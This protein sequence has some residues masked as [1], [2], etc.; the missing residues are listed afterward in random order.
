MGSTS[1]KI[2]T[3]PNFST[4]MCWSNAA[5]ILLS[6]VYDEPSF[7]RPLVPPIVIDLSS[8]KSKS[9]F[10]SSKPAIMST[11][12]ASWGPCVVLDADY[13]IF[14]R[15]SDES[16]SAVPVELQVSAFVDS[17]CS[18]QSAK[19]KKRKARGDM[20]FWMAATF[21]A[22]ACCSLYTFIASM[23]CKI[24]SNKRSRSFQPNPEF[25]HV[26]AA[27]FSEITDILP[28]ATLAANVEQAQVLGNAL[29]SQEDACKK[30]ENDTADLEGNDGSSIPD[31]I[32]SVVMPKV[33]VFE[34]GWS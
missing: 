16:K 17:T 28:E 3:S 10:A 12:E 1:E 5:D 26:A 20:S 33:A 14:V 29:V 31:A 32:A 21:A 2:E 22:L 13:F 23:F 24:V 7:N 9:T 30:K 6:S 25:A 27:F 19:K 8:A 11:A 34:M 4:A 15:N 18:S